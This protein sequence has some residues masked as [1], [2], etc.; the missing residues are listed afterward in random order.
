MEASSPIRITLQPPG[1]CPDSARNGFCCCVC[2]RRPRCADEAGADIP[3]VGRPADLPFSGAS[4]DF[5]VWADAA[6]KTLEAQ[7][8]LT[9]TLHVEARSDVLHPPR[10]IDLRELPSFKDRFTFEEMDAGGEPPTGPNWE[11]VYR[12]HPK[13]DSV[14]A[15]PGIPFVF[16]NPDIQYPRKGFQVAYTDPIALTVKPPA[17][18]VVPVPGP[19]VLFSCAR[20]PAVAATW[21]QGRRPDRGPSRRCCRRRRCCAWAGTW[22]G[23]GC[24]P[25]PPGWR[26]GDAARPPVAPCR[27]CERLADCSRSNRPRAAAVTAD[28]LRGRFDAPAEEPT[29]AEA[30]ACLGRAGCSP[31]LAEQAAAF[32]R[33]CDAARFAPD[34]PPQPDLTDAAA[35][36]ILAVEAETWSASRS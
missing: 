3:T 16:Y 6:P 35:R 8:P 18:Y 25:T 15:V 20:G 11:F 36:F 17:V 26:S 28:Y 22:A 14:T 32:F 34:G 29:P 5:R 24:T 12:L 30:A 9:L 1:P 21:A 4:G 27:R 19:E 23:G 33:A 7:T 13:G 10:R 2:C 31:V